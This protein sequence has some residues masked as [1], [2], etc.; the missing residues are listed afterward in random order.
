MRTGCDGFD[1][2][3]ILKACGEAPSPEFEA[4]LGSCA[5]CQ[6]EVAEHREIERAYV[7]A[8]TETMPAAVIARFRR[9]VSAP[10]LR[11]RAVVLRVAAAAAVVAVAVLM[12]SLLAPGRGTATRTPP[13][14]TAAAVEWEPVTPAGAFVVEMTI[15]D[16]LRAARARADRVL[17]E[18]A[19][20][21][22][23]EL[24]ALR[25][26]AEALRIDGDGM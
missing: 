19:S 25:R 26:R 22:D 9:R 15:D 13:P 21:V 8:S 20:D 2:D 1:G 18:P 16:R 17:A 4:H 23:R 24:E 11:A 5:A 10:P 12:W 6:A 7:D 3:R 14:A